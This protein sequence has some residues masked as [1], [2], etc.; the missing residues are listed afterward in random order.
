DAR[1]RNAELLSK[2]L[3]GVPGLRLPAVEP[4]RT[5][6]WHQYTVLVTEDAL[7][8]RDELST[9]L[10][11]LGVGNGIY[12]P[13]VA[14]DYDCYRS[15][16]GVIEADVPVARRVARQALSLPVHP[17]LSDNDL[18]TIVGRVREVLGV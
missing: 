8:T 16:P 12:Y 10:T 15:H 9:R 4:D 17:K 3:S 5:H 13:K 11:E 6:V 18:D 1:R 14:F 7:L 2:G